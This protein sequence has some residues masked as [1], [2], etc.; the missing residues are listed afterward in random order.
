MQNGLY[1]ATSGLLMQ[2]NRMD[3]ISNNLSNMNT[4]GFK[5]DLAVFSVHRP[6]DTRYPQ[7]QVRET[8]YNKTINTAVQLDDIFVNHE[9]GAMKPTNNKLDFAIEQKNAFFAIDTPWGIRYTKNGEFTTNADGDL[10]TRDGYPVMSRG[11]QGTAN[12]NLPANTTFEVDR[13][14]TIFANGVAGEALLIVEFD[15][16]SK[17]QKVGRNEFAAVDIEPVESDNAGVRQ[18]YVEGSNVDPISEMVRMIEATRGYEMY[19][20]VVQTYD[21]LDEQASSA[22]SRQA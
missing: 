11:A 19:S 22:I 5:K 3:T 2:Q 4:T 12:I 1:V 8:H 18:G 21:N 9:M 15:D 17:L 6:N 7:Q 20:K 10:V 14:G 13:T 16:L